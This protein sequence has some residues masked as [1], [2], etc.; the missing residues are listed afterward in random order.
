MNEVNILLQ[1][2]KRRE[3]CILCIQ[4][5]RNCALQPCGHKDLCKNCADKLDGTCHVCR[6]KIE[7]VLLLY[8]S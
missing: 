5:K 2:S 6:V 8:S 3:E 7:S 1:K 4:N